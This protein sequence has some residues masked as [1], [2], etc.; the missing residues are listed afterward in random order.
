MA[1]WEEIAVWFVL[2]CEWGRIVTAVFQEKETIMIHQSTL[3][4][5]VAVG[6]L[7]VAGTMSLA[8][9]CRASDD[10]AGS[11][12]TG[13]SGNC[14]PACHYKCITT[15]VPRTVSYTKVVTLYDHCGQPYQASQTCYRTIRVPVQRVVLDCAY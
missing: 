12:Q 13:S 5:I 6:L 8:G 1:S 7:S 9:T 15:Y 4:R 10:S 3:R 14:R 2:L 11:Y